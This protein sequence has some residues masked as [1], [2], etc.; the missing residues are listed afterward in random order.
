MRTEGFLYS[1]FHNQV[2]AQNLERRKGIENLCVIIII[3]F[4]V[5]YDF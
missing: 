1:L 2:F 4:I 5:K 3:N